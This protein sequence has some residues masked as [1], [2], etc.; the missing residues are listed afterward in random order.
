MLKALKEYDIYI[1]HITSFMRMIIAIYLI[2]YD[3]Y[4][5]IYD[6]YLVCNISIIR[7][8]NN[9]LSISRHV[10]YIIILIGLK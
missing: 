2:T 4:L 1:F 10:T 5:F 7:I 8:I 3:I 6:L 9:D